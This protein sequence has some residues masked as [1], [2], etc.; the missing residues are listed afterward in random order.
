MIAFT[1]P[2]YTLQGLTL[3]LSRGIS[4]LKHEKGCPIFL[5]FAHKSPDFT[6]SMRREFV[7]M[8]LSVKQVFASFQSIYRSADD[9][10]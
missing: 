5:S 9:R 7:R 2:P 3:F 4:A 8:G 6:W 1:D 10:Q